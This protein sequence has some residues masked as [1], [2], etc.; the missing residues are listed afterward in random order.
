[1]ERRLPPGAVYRHGRSGQHRSRGA[2]RTRASLDA[3]RATRPPTTPCVQA[4]AGTASRW[5]NNGTGLLRCQ[6]AVPKTMSLTLLVPEVGLPSLAS[7]A[8]HAARRSSLTA[9]D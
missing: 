2:L 3:V 7:F 8:R 5:R 9:A 6:D 4:T 1:P